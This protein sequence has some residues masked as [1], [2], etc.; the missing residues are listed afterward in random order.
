MLY[1]IQTY[2][3]K[4]SVLTPLQNLF[5]S[6]IP[7]ATQGCPTKVMITHS[8][9]VDYNRDSTSSGAEQ[10]GRKAVVAKQNPIEGVREAEFPGI[11]AGI[12]MQKRQ[13]QDKKHILT[14]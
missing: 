2:C 1:G 12:P 4:D 9:M 13:V 3:Q 11:Q 10:E 14:R 6:G 8:H 7:S 5:F